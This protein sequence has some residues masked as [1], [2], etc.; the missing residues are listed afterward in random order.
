MPTIKQKMAF[1]KVLAGTTLTKAMKEAKYST[2]TSN[3][4]G[5]LT[6]SKG[7][8]ELIDRHLSDS[9]LIKKHRELLDKR[10][11][12]GEIDVQAVTKGLDMAYKLKGS[13]APE[14][15]VSLNVNTSEEII[16]KSKEAINQ[17]LI[18]SLNDSGNTR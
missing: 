8:K 15:S 2:T 18:D 16:K 13:Y 4:T 17:F 11:A 10:E 5:K 1:K 12:N 3:T 14:K 6:R 7:W 9:L